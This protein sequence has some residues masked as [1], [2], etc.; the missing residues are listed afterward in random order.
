MSWTNKQTNIR[1]KSFAWHQFFYQVNYLGSFGCILNDKKCVESNIHWN[2][3]FVHPQ[4]CIPV[5]C[6]SAKSPWAPWGYFVMGLTA[7][8]LITLLEHEKIR[9]EQELLSIPTTRGSL[10]LQKNNI[11]PWKERDVF[12]LSVRSLSDWHCDKRIQG[13]NPLLFQVYLTSTVPFSNAYC[14]DAAAKGPQEYPCDYKKET[15]RVPVR[16]SVPMEICHAT[17]TWLTFL[18]DIC[19][20]WHAWQAKRQYHAV[21]V[22]HFVC[23]STTGNVSFHETLQLE[24]FLMTSSFLPKKTGP[25]NPKCVHQFYHC[26]D[27]SWCHRLA[28]SGFSLEEQE[29]A[30]RTKSHWVENKHCHCAKTEVLLKIQYNQNV[31][32][33]WH[34]G[35]FLV[36]C[37]VATRC[38]GTKHIRHGGQDSVDSTFS[39][40]IGLNF[41]HIWSKDFGLVWHCAA[42]RILFKVH[43]F[44]MLGQ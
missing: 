17:F 27:V 16:T 25:W 38:N 6:V 20:H 28:S 18:Q 9:D 23:W 37:A 33:P 21:Y 44:G 2:E 14:T 34:C 32:L 19:K 1:G 41:I 26:L 30:S 3:S 42:G 35:W 40:K 39:M 24:I 8:R 11:V 12:W 15:W 29:W 10:L 5:A 4:R 31:P 36:I 22:W 13:N 7:C 43:N